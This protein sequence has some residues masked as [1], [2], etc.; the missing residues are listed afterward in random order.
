MCAYSFNNFYSKFI[1]LALEVEY[2]SKMLIRKFNHKLTPRFQD[3]LNSNVKLTL[4]IS[5][6]A[7]RCLSIYKQIQATDKIR[8][9]IKPLQ[10]TQ[11]LVSTNSRVGSHQVS[12]INTCANTFFSRFSSSISRIMSATP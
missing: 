4:S 9:R 6:L 10:S 5:A 12:A 1:C 7:K 2:I 8:N 11:S 3:R